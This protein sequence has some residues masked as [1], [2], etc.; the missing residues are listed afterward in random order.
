MGCESK[1]LYDIGSDKAI[2]DMNSR[3]KS[4]EE[5]LNTLKGDLEKVREVL[6]DQDIDVELRK[7]LK[8]E[9]HEAEKYEKE[10]HQWLSYVKVQRKQRYNSLLRRKNS[11]TLSAEAEKEVKAYFM[12]KKLKPIKKGWKTRYKTA[13]EM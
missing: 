4:F 7:S 2:S 5:D 1:S 12:Q 10:I 8:K 9:I 6:K 11:K 3:I 13:I